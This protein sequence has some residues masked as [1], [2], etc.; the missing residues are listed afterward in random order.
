[1]KRL[2]FS[3]VA[4]QLLL[5]AMLIVSGPRLPQYS[6]GWI[7]WASAAALALWA[8]AS[9]RLHSLSIFPEPVHGGQLCQNGP[10]RLVRH[11]MY[12]ALLILCTAY[13]VDHLSVWRL[14]ATILLIIVLLAKI[15]IEEA[16]LLGK[17][18]E[19]EGYRKHTWRIVPYVW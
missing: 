5:L 17:Y 18:P 13:C 14:L 2:S 1:M 9:V 15:S 10:Y 16:L 7:L 8:V 11:P 12:L 4:S 3:L 6:I 19:Y